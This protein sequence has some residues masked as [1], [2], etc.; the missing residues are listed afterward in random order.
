M[1]RINTSSNKQKRNYLQMKRL[2]VLLVILAVATS[3]VGCRDEMS[4]VGDKPIN[5]GTNRTVS[6]YVD[7][8]VENPGYYDVA[9]GTDVQTAVLTK[10]V[11]SMSGALP[12]DGHAAVKNGD[13][14]IVGFV[15]GNGRYNSV[16]A[17]SAFVKAR[18]DVDGVS[19]DVVD[20]LASYLETHGKVQNRTELRAALG[21]YYEDNY[22]K[23]YVSEVDYR[24]D[25]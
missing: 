5:G 23:F 7:G 2:M 3:L 8:A 15:D 13:S 17:N 1:F 22:Y 21:D 10:A 25:D 16:N 6:I 18:M 19:A 14:V 11:L 12:N 24:A 20:R 9:V 4:P